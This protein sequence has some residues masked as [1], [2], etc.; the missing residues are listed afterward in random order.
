MF[1]NNCPMNLS[2]GVKVNLY[3]YVELASRLARLRAHLG[4][5]LRMVV[6]YWLRNAPHT[7]RANGIALNG[8]GAD[9]ATTEHSK[10]KVAPADAVADLRRRHEGGLT[11]DGGLRE[12][13]A[14]AYKGTLVCA[15]LLRLL[16]GASRPS[17]SAAQPPPDRGVLLEES[18]AMFEWAREFIAL[19]DA[20]AQLAPPPLAPRLR[21]S[22]FAPTLQRIALTEAL[23]TLATLDRHLPSDAARSARKHALALE[24]V[25]VVRRAP[26][27]EPLA[28]G[29]DHQVG[30]VR[31][32]LALAHSSLASLFTLSASHVDTAQTREHAFAGAAEHYRAAADAELDDARDAA[33]YCWG[34][35]ANMCMTG[36]A[37]RDG[38]VAPRP[39]DGGDDGAEEGRAPPRRE[40]YTVGELKH[41]IAAAERAARARD[42]ALWGADEQPKSFE[43]IARQM[44]AW[45]EKEGDG[46]AL[47]GATIA[48]DHAG[49][50][51][52]TAAGGF[53]LGDLS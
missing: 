46:F 26:L 30:L 32:P 14:L 4:D 21:G 27:P 3:I 8:P 53:V 34:Y 35:A 40:S 43:S 38:L 50:L 45:F 10:R 7:L 19:A 12:L 15:H 33:V 16:G 5:E 31:K 51:R 13:V 25:T 1:S 28:A 2:E 47:P 48:H 23:C 44:L 37:R 9:A 6:P 39:G 22:S 42:T 49:K 17:S 24:L 18:L 29:A 36:A 41:A 52:M 20:D 11:W